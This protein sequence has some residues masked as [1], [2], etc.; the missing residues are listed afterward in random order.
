MT[1]ATAASDKTNADLVAFKALSLY[2]LNKKS[3]ALALIDGL[4][5]RSNEPAAVAWYTT[6]ETQCSDSNPS[7]KT[8]LE[9]FQQALQHAPNNAV[10][11]YLLGEAYLR[12]GENSL[13]LENWRVASAH[14]PSW[15]EPQVRIAEMLASEGR[16]SAE[17]SLE[18]SNAAQHALSAGS[19]G[20]NEHEVEV[21]TAQI[22]VGYAQWQASHDSQ[23]AQDVLASVQNL[24]KQI[25]NEPETLPIYVDLLAQ[26]GS[27]DQAVTVIRG[28]ENDA[29]KVGEDLLLRLARLSRASQLHMESEIYATIQKQFGLTPGLAQ[30]QAN[31]LLASGNAPQGMQLLQSARDKGL[32]A[33]IGTPIQWDLALCQ[34]RESS[35]D[36]SAADAW[37]Q[38][39]DA[40][41]D[42]LV[43]QSKI[44][45]DENSA[46][47]NRPFID[48]TI[49]R[50]KNL[51]GDDAIGWKVYRARYLVDGDNSQ[52]DAAAAVVLL[53]DVL[54]LTKTDVGPHVLMALANEKLQN[55]PAA[56]T[57]WRQAADLAPNSGK[58]LWGLLRT[59]DMDNQPDEA[60]LAF[61]R[62]ANVPDLSPDLALQASLLIAREGDLPRAQ[63]LLTAY[64]TDSNQMLHDAT[65]AKVDRMLG[66]IND[67]ATY[68]FK[69]VDAPGLDAGTIRDAADF[70]ASQHDLPPARKFLA[71]LDGLNLP[72]GQKEMIL[73]DFEDRYGDPATAAKLY[74]D[75]VQS[76]G[77][78][79][80]AA[81]AQ[82]GYLIRRQQY[83]AA[84]TAL[85]LAIA[86]WQNDAE[87]ASLKNINQTLAAS[88][89]I[90]AQAPDLINYA[91]RTPTDPAASATLAAVAA[92][93]GQNADQA[94]QAMSDLVQNYPR[95][96]PA[97]EL[98]VRSLIS[99]RRM[100]DAVTMASDAMVQFPESADA[101]RISAEAYAAVG[102]WGDCILAASKWRQRGADQPLQA[103]IMIAIAD[104]FSDQAGDAVGRLAPYIPDAKNS[105]D[106]HEDVLIT[107]AEALIRS[108]DEPDAIALLHPLAEKSARW[109]A[110]WLKIASIAHA[111]GPSA[112][113]W[114]DQIRPLFDPNSPADQ[115]K[116]ADAYFDVA[117]HLN[118]PKAFQMAR[119]TLSPFVD[120]PGATTS[121]LMTYALSCGATGDD[122][123]AERAYRQLLKIDP[124]QPAAQNNLA[125][126]LR[127][128]DSPDALSEAETLARSAI[129]AAPNDPNTS[130]FCDTLAR[131]LLKEGRVDDAIAV[132][133]QGEQLQ[134]K[135][136]SVLIGLAS[137]YAHANRIDDASRYL[138]RIDSL[139]PP[140][141]QLPAD[142]QTELDAA[143]DIV[144]KATA[145][146]GAP[147]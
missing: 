10:I 23:Q 21:V 119:D 125:D 26:T 39:G 6:L 99:D 109:R 58:V 25:P 12:M 40:H 110:D 138:N 142:S 31:D 43:V 36:P 34:F 104:L 50:L 54:A 82:I 132:F 69:I 20:S 70:F 102:R 113:A 42:D 17:A 120:S 106:L 9:K 140:N 37:Q 93:A 89:Q 83:A 129:A 44:L 118:D 97:Y 101:A 116:I 146:S 47:S 53:N 63:R 32:A 123:T 66:Q 85:N 16:G 144:K 108:G 95:F 94:A 30:A 19:T 133:Q 72:N 41:P 117:I 80:D 88:P 68:Y 139:L 143:R 107:Y 77:N 61:D 46:W 27:P 33:G 60:R 7:L 128:K 2:Q 100:D 62:L 4:S 78:Q 134:P 105:P 48:R 135:N 147:Q 5:G 35:G 57:E 96:F 18:A 141:A 59:L 73:A 121:V 112:T 124:K 75:A 76:G 1:P 14:S 86:Q 51:T 74:T 90:A 15:A 28:A 122:V 114:I 81:K 65:L 87:L 38:L 49:N 29:G 71:R 127:K 145:T 56:I 11:S 136:F 91:T 22:L 130:N 13:A 67:A 84:T 52:T 103:D 111:D 45:A 24:Q 98:A 115:E 3:D 126:I 64:P 8:R 137:A 55:Y 131:T 92:T 79:P